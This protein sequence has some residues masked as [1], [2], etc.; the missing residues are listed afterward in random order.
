MNV[1]ESRRRGPRCLQPS[2]HIVLSLLFVEL[3]FFLCGGVLILLVFRDEVV[4]VALSFGELHFIH[5]FPS[6]PM[7]ES[8]SAKHS[9]EVLRNTF[10][11]FLDSSTVASEGHGH[12]QALRWDVADTRFDVVR[13]PLHEVTAVLIL[14]I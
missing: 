1:A 9:R 11:H 7:Q 14:N 12:L 3:A 13:N 4:H 6:V 2:L 8:L 5:T 10:E